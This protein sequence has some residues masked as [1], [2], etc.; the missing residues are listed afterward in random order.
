MLEENV[1]ACGGMHS[2]VMSL[3][4]MYSKEVVQMFLQQNGNKLV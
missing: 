2:Y 3:E 1:Q 4:S